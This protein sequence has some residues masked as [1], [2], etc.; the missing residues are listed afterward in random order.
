MAV[1]EIETEETAP[2]MV[3]NAEGIVLIGETDGDLVG[4]TVGAG[5]MKTSQLQNPMKI[6]GFILR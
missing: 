6:F 3:G 5:V 1:P 4:T 2:V